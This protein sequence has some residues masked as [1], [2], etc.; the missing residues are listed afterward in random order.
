MIF[1]TRTHLFSESKEMLVGKKRHSRDNVE[2][3]ERLLLRTILT[4]IQNSTFV[5]CLT[6]HVT[7]ISKPRREVIRITYK[8]YPRAIISAI[9]GVVDA[10]VKSLGWNLTV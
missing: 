7:I 6:L 3:I 8:S 5:A 1:S 2:L 10:I 4:P 9:E